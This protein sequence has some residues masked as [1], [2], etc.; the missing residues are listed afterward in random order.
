[1]TS[2]KVSLTLGRLNCFEVPVESI[3]N[4]YELYQSIAYGEGFA[5]LVSYVEPIFAFEP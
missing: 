2:Q 3:Q 1:V 5:P 4:H